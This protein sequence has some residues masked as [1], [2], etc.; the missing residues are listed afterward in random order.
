MTMHVT[1]AIIGATVLLAPV[2][3]ANAQDQDQTRPERSGRDTEAIA[4]A[5]DTL[6]LSEEQLGRIREIRRERPPRGQSREEA[7]AWREAQQS[8]IEDVLT[9]E[10]KSRVAEL[11]EVR[12]QMEALAGAT[13]LGLVQGGR[14]GPWANVGKP[15]G[16]RDRRGPGGR[17]RTFL[18]RRGPHVRGWTGAHGHGH[19]GARHRKGGFGPDRRRGKARGDA[20]SQSR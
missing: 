13:A 8:K 15:Q 9:D 10:Q 12:H 19:R 2:W 6:A 16:M 18:S 17:V 14:N 7:Q 1:R 4:A 5:A 20:E 11:A 3:A